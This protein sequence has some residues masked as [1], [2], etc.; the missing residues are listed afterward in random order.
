MTSDRRGY[1]D[2]TGLAVGPGSEVFLGPARAEVP[3]GRH[4][5]EAP[6]G[7][8]RAPAAHEWSVIEVSVEHRRHHQLKT[9]GLW[10]SRHD[11]TMDALTWTTLAGRSYRTDPFDYREVLDA[12]LDDGPLVRRRGAIPAEQRLCSATAERHLDAT[13]N[14]GAGGIGIPPLA[15]GDPARNDASDPPPF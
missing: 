11:P 15:D 2:P 14:G 4:C 7:R 6:F 1:A 13:A 9:V 3:F 12:D 5:A 8:D 10:S